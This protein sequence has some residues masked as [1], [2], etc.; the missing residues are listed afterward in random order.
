MFFQECPYFLFD[1]KRS[2]A[3]T[4]ILAEPDVAHTASM[5]LTIIDPGSW[6]PPGFEP[7]PFS[8]VVTQEAMCIF[9]PCNWILF[10][11]QDLVCEKISTHQ[12]HF[13]S[14]P[15]SI[16]AWPGNML[17]SILALCKCRENVSRFF[18]STLTTYLTCP[19]AH[20]HL[21]F[22]V[23]QI[24][25]LRELPSIVVSHTRLIS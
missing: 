4:A 3:V 19:S 9:L 5:I 14:C 25:S 16:S 11:M 17:C 7:T 22:A 23:Q 1:G 2:A 10:A 6:L 20:L 12:L 21:S 8:A 18:A 24:H 13:E 15:S